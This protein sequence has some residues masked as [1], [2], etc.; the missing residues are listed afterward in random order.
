MLFFPPFICHMSC[1]G[2]YYHSTRSRGFQGLIVLSPLPSLEWLQIAWNLHAERKCSFSPSFLFLCSRVSALVLRALFSIPVFRRTPVRQKLSLMDSLPSALEHPNTGTPVCTSWCLK[3][4]ERHRDFEWPPPEVLLQRCQ[5]AA[6]SKQ[7]APMSLCELVPQGWYGGSMKGISL[8]NLLHCG[9]K[10][11]DGK[12]LPRKMPQ[13]NSEKSLVA[14][15]GFIQKAFSELWINT[16]WNSSLIYLS[17]F[18]KAFKQFYLECSCQQTNE[19]MFKKKKQ[20]QK[21]ILLQL[22]VTR[23]PQWAFCLRLSLTILFRWPVKVHGTV[24][25]FPERMDRLTLYLH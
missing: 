10:K 7:G 16:I 4:R 14:Y 17:Y 20:R 1:L 21:P 19:I 5:T 18:S 12:I 23:H 13:E 24:S 22:F 8:N 6:Q 9:E 11:R 3:Q 15:Y 2:F 25:G